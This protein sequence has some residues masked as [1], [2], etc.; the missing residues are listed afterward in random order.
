MARDLRVPRYPYPYIFL[1]ILSDLRSRSLAKWEEKN[2]FCGRNSSSSSQSTSTCS[3][4]PVFFSLYLS[5]FPSCWLLSTIE[6]GCCA[7]NR[8]WNRIPLS[9]LVTFRNCFQFYC[10]WLYKRSLTSDTHGNRNRYIFMPHWFQAMP[11][12]FCRGF[13]NGELEITEL[14]LFCTSFPRSYVS[15]VP[16]GIKW[17]PRYS[18]A[19]DGK[20]KKI[21]VDYHP[22]ESQLF[23]SRPSQHVTVGSKWLVNADSSPSRRYPMCLEHRV[24]IRISA[25]VKIS[26]YS[27]QIKSGI[28]PQSQIPA[29]EWFQI[30]S[31]TKSWVEASS[32]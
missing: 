1:P 5:C 24:R 3:V 23:H 6:T 29:N 18:N 17:V 2:V 12:L 22:K 15:L 32:Y 19:F 16:F 7:S 25:S 10:T 31:F 8:R 4:N 30:V 9:F 14:V 13:L 21:W 28:T 20:Y 27:S 11:A 26:H